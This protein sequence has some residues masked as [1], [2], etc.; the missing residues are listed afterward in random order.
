MSDNYENFLT[1]LMNF[2]AGERANFR[3]VKVQQL[4]NGEIIA[5]EQMEFFPEPTLD[6]TPAAI[7]ADTI[8]RIRYKNRMYEYNNKEVVGTFKVMDEKWGGAIS[9][10]YFLSNNS[11]VANK[12]YSVEIIADG[13]QAYNGSWDKFAA[14]TNYLQDVSCFDD[15]TNYFLSFNTIFFD[16]SI[17][18]RI[19]NAE[20]PTFLTIFVKSIQRLL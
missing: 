17:S 19:Y 16:K 20:S 11:V 12:S 8:K 3:T 15:G 1:R 18:I 9:E 13:N 5:E 4:E 2:L 7:I 6:I 10:V 14:L